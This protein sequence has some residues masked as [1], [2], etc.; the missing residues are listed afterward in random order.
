MRPPCNA[1]VEQ[2]YRNQRVEKKKNMSLGI[3][4]IAFLHT[5]LRRKEKLYKHVPVAKCN[6]YFTMDL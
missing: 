4:F 3:H 1:H 5:L 6:K 2:N